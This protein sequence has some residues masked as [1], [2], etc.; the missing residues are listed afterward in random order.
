M[1]EFTLE[2]IHTHQLHT[3]WGDTY[4]DACRR[5]HIDENLWEVIDQEYV[6]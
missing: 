1:Y 6:D 5:C 4:T 3:I 2:H